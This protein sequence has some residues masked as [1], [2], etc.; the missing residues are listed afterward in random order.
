MAGETVNEIIAQALNVVNVS[1]DIIH[2][3]RGLIQTLSIDKKVALAHQL[4]IKNSKIM[5]ALE[6]FCPKIKSAVDRYVD[7]VGASIEYRQWV[8][9]Y[10]SISLLSKS[11]IEGCQWFAKIVSGN[12]TFALKTLQTNVDENEFKRDLAIVKPLDR[13]HV[14]SAVSRLKDLDLIS[15]FHPWHVLPATCHICT[16]KN[17][18]WRPKT[19]EYL[20]LR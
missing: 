9:I 5:S 6:S 3:I 4:N 2:Q 18:T 1:Q 12:E 10:H 8:R 16:L 15:S 20:I 19:H 13:I 11:D 14:C 17:Q 7:W